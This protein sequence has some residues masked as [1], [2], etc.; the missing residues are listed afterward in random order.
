MYLECFLYW[1]APDGK[2]QAMPYGCLVQHLRNP[3]QVERKH[4]IFLETNS[5]LQLVGS[6]GRKVL[7]RETDYIESE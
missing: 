4:F 5:A 3:P 1:W 2:Q 7:R 6:V